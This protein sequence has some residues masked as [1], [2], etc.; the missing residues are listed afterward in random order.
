MAKTNTM[1]HLNIDTHLSPLPW[2]FTAIKW[3]I[4]LVCAGFTSFVLGAI[5][6]GYLGV[7]AAL[8]GLASIA[9]LYANLSA[10]AA[11]ALL[12]TVMIMSAVVIGGALSLLT[13]ASL[14]GIAEAYNSYNIQNA[15]VFAKVTQAK[16]LEKMQAVLDERDEFVVEKDRVIK[17][18]EQEIQ[19]LREQLLSRPT[20]A[21]VLHAQPPRQP[22]A[23]TVGRV[24]EGPA[25][26]AEVS[27]ASSSDDETPQQQ[28]QEKLRL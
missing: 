14:L 25:N 18:Q 27:S 11:F 26:D 28:E 3:G 10:F 22:V 19:A 1:R 23:D 12:S 7:P 20:P 17:K 24:L 2:W 21:P 13:R 4:P 15:T 8:E 16:Q 5:T 9:V 6:T